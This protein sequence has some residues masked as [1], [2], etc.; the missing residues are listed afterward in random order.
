MNI[1]EQYDSSYIGLGEP[2]MTD[3]EHHYCAL[4]YEEKP[5][6]IQTDRICYSFKEI[7]DVLY[8]SLVSQ[9]YALW[10]E[11]LHKHC[12][13]LIYEKST[14]WFEEELSHV[15]IEHSFLSPLKTNILNGCYDVVCKVEPTT[16]IA[17]KSGKK[18]THPL[19]QYKIIPTIHIKGI[20]FNSKHFKLD[21]VL[22]SVV[23][24]EEIDSEN[25]TDLESETDLEEINDE[26]ELSELELTDIQPEGV[27]DL[28]INE[29]EFVEVYSFLDKKIRNDVLEHLNQMCMK[30]RIKVNIDLNELFEEEVESD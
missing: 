3:N 27:A 1:L 14:N 8:I 4:S 30:K 18:I 9:D 23:V 20:L 12:V 29:N 17:D 21:L 6:V 5:F 22:T 15:D 26:L 19:N 11:S 13:D 16:L 10:I 25:D 24:L 7:S 28:H 2:Q